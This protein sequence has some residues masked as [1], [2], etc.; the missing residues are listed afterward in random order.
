[1]PSIISGNY[2]LKLTGRATGKSYTEKLIVD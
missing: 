2:F 1:M